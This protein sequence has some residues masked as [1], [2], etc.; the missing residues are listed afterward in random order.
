MVFWL[1]NVVLTLFS[2]WVFNLSRWLQQHHVNKKKVSTRL[3]VEKNK[4][5]IAKL[6]SKNQPMAIFPDG[7]F[8]EAYLMVYSEDVQNRQH[9][10]SRPRRSP[11]YRK[12]KKSRRHKGRKSPCKKHH[13]N[14]DFSEVSLSTVHNGCTSALYSASK[15]LIGGTIFVFYPG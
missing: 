10:L 3:S 2:R 14:V 13:L 7:D 6:D 8:T 5:T 1:R 4:M 12:K 11:D 15:N 9:R